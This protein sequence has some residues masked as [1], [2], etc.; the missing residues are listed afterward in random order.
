MDLQA[1]DEGGGVVIAY[2][3]SALTDDCR[4]PKLREGTVTVEVHSRKNLRM[5]LARA[6]GRRFERVY[7]Y[8][9]FPDQSLVIHIVGPGGNHMYYA[10]ADPERRDDQ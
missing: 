2:Q 8:D 1:L 9:G 4:I 7:K 5:G 10:I 3:I 6:F